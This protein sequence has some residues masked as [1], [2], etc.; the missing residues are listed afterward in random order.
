MVTE[1]NELEKHM[2]KTMTIDVLTFACRKT[3]QK[4][5]FKMAVSKDKKKEEIC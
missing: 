2:T 3:K 5:R 4:A 1:V